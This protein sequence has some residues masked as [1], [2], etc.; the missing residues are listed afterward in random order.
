MFAWFAWIWLLDLLWNTFALAFELI[1]VCLIFL[2]VVLVH[3]ALVVKLF[4]WI[5]FFVVRMARTKMVPRRYVDGRITANEV[6]QVMREAA[7]VQSDMRRE[8]EEREAEFNALKRQVGL[9]TEEELVADAEREHCGVFAEEERAQQEE[10]A[11]Q[12]MYNAF[13]HDFEKSCQ[14]KAPSP[15]FVSPLLRTPTRSPRTIFART[16]YSDEH[17]DARRRWLSGGCTP[18]RAPRKIRRRVPPN[19]PRSSYFVEKVRRNLFHECPI[20]MEE[21]HEVHDQ[22]EDDEQDDDLQFVLD[23]IVKYSPSKTR[24]GKVYSHAC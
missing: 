18:L 23:F 15:P 24:N 17:L 8:A 10:R 19:S 12:Q 3:L 2:F 5:G 13:V 16:C 4:Y 20:V 22:N 9:A 21:E 7:Q 11:E 14:T 1:L 6:R